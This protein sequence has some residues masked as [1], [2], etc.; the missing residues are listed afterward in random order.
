V[1]YR[2]V[3]LPTALNDL[4]TANIRQWAGGHCLGGHEG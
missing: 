1:P 4:A 2:Y 3:D